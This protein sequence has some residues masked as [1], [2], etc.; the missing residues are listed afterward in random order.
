M[1]QC[2]CLWF[3]W[4]TREKHVW[5]LKLVILPGTQAQ[6]S[7]PISTQAVL[8]LTLWFSPWNLSLSFFPSH[9]NL[10]CL[11]LQCLQRFGE[12]YTISKVRKI[13][14]EVSQ[15]CSAAFFRLWV[16]LCWVCLKILVPQILP[17]FVTYHVSPIKW[18][19]HLSGHAPNHCIFF[20]CL[21]PLLWLLNKGRDLHGL[22][23]QN[24]W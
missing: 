13:L 5:F 2:L 6:R 8:T 14:R 7:A 22:Y 17:I 9:V 10:D 18:M 16:S 20:Y 23:L 15:A 4:V 1:S 24:K 11:R 19:S 21:I 12:L 3:T